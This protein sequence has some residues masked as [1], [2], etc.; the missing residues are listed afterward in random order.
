[1]KH[2]DLRRLFTLDH[3]SLALFR[4]SLGLCLFFD[5]IYRAFYIEEFY[6]D[7]GIMPREALISK[8]MG[9][10]EISLHLLNGTWTIQFFIFLIAIAAAACFTLGYHTRV[11]AFVSWVLL[12][13]MQ[14]R[15]LTVLHG[16]DDM[17]RV[18]FFWC[19]F[20]PLAV[21]FSLDKYLNHKKS[22]FSY[23]ALNVGTAGIVLQMCFLYFFTALLKWHPIWHTEGS[24]VHYALG[25]DEFTSPLGIWIRQFPG[26]MKLMTFATLALE[27]FGPLIVLLP[28]RS[29]SP[30]LLMCLA[31][32]G[33]HISL[34]I[35]M[36]LGFFPW[37]CISGWLALLPSEFWKKVGEPFSLV[38][39]IS[40]YAK[41]LPKPPEPRI[42]FTRLNQFMGTIMLSFILFWNLSHFET[43]MLEKPQWLRAVMNVTATYQKWSMFA[44]YPRKDDGWYVV[45][46]TLINGQVVDPWNGGGPVSLERPDNIANT[47]RNSMWRKYMTNLWLKTYSEYR[48][49]LGRY[50]CRVWNET[51]PTDEQINTM[52]ISYMLEMTPPPG[53][54]VPEVSKELIWRHY[55]FNKPDN[56]DN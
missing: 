25:L 6:T 4:I 13:S 47:Y 44:P 36:E 31:F 19:Q 46:A 42:Y 43:L 51:H 27:F 56:W 18:L 2:L 49:Y 26:V 55:C 41:K 16:G 21:E 9:S 30:R 3:R 8:F 1:M 54:P 17:F 23:E 5:L 32:I 33:F 14:A 15:N 20:T 35:F 45:E 50:F 52:K 34:S 12:C 37:V 10:W 11:A 24:A 22:P 38:Q 7:R 53:E 48:V 40:T 39:K 28:I 29:G